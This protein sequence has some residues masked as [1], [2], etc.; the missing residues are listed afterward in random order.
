ML[1]KILKAL[2][3]GTIASIENEAIDQRWF[4]TQEANILSQY[5]SFANHR[6]HLIELN[7]LHQEI[8]DLEVLD[9]LRSQSN[10]EDEYYY[11]LR[12]EHERNLEDPEYYERWYE[13]SEAEYVT[14][15]ADEE[16]EA[17]IRNKMG[18]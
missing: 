2:F 16:T 12:L 3:P 13:E 4:N 8:H 15:I 5:G 18:S 9:R 11:Y 10:D 6:D 1:K 14:R 7:R 17:L